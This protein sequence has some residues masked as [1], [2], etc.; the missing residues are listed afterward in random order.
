MKRSQR[1]QMSLTLQTRDR[2]DSH[3]NRRVGR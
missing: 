1:P 2:A 3:V